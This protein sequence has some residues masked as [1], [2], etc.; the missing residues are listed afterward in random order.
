[1]RPLKDIVRDEIFILGRLRETNPDLRWIPDG[2]EP[3]GMAAYNNDG[4]VFKIKQVPSERIPL[5]KVIMLLKWGSE[6]T[7]DSIIEILSQIETETRLR[8]NYQVPT[9][10]RR[11]SYFSIYYQ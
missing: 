6:P 8:Q 10:Q 5:A 7:D 3:R 4:K 2:I 1:M 11:Y 9:P